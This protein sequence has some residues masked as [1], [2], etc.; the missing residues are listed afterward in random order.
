MPIFWLCPS[1]NP[2]YVS[3]IDTLLEADF[4]S[5]ATHFRFTCPYRFLVGDSLTTSK[6]YVLLVRPVLD[7]LP[8]ASTRPCLIS[9]QRFILYPIKYLDTCMEY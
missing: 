7:L 4:G 8:G 6:L 9:L 3:R 5:L 1:G 2:K